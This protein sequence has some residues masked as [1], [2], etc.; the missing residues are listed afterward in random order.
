PPWHADPRYGQFR[1]SRRMSSEEID[2]LAA[3]VDAGMP[4][5]DDKDLP[6]PIDWPSGWTLGQPD[7]V[8]S[9]PEEFDVPATGIVPYKNWVVETGFTEDRWV[10]MAEARPGSA[11]VHHVSVFLVK[12]GEADASLPDGTTSIVVSWA[13]GDLGLVCPP[14]T[15]LR[16][17]K[18]A[19][20]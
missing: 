6:K 1:N 9:M 4:R 13:P 17:P 10:R 15:A 16:I 7:V 19:K 2:T 8:L 18:G 11:P 12:P 3:W 14:D 20:I 5:G